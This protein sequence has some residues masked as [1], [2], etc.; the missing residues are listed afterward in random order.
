MHINMILQNYFLYYF[1][2]RIIFLYTIFTGNFY[3]LFYTK[4]S[5]TIKNN[6]KIKYSAHYIYI[7]SYRR[8]INNQIYS[9]FRLKKVDQRKKNLLQIYHKSF[10][11]GIYQECNT[12]VHLFLVIHSGKKKR[13][14][15]GESNIQRR[16]IPI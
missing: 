12:T 3:R 13:E 5:I 7:Y 10:S 1:V 9:S 2:G 8:L 4:A 11:H 14:G 15:E 6:I 16:I